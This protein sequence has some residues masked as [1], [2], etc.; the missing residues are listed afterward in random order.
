MPERSV[1]VPKGLRVC[2][3]DIVAGHR[4]DGT[5][6]VVCEGACDAMRLAESLEGHYRKITASEAPRR[7]VHVSRDDPAA[8]E[9]VPRQRFEDGCFHRD[10]I[11]SEPVHIYI[12]DR[13]FR[14]IP[15]IR[16]TITWVDPKGKPFQ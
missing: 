15:S 7:G 2:I 11:T 8:F 3:E 5:I 16:G 9:G 4:Q 13:P 10:R 12:A 6:I 1:S 14:V